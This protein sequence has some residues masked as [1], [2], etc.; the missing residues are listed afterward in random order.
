[1]K[2]FIDLNPGDP[3]YAIWISPKFGEIGFDVRKTDILCSEIIDD[4]TLRLSFLNIIVSGTPIFV[5]CNP[6]ET[7]FGRENC[8]Y[9][10]DYDEFLENIHK[11]EESTMNVWYVRHEDGKDESDPVVRMILTMEQEIDKIYEKVQGFKAG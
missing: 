3:L 6:T 8:W 7:C 1:M 10:S 2:H 11:L 4:N 5:H 9:F